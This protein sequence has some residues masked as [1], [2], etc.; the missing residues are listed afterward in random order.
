MKENILQLKE[1]QDID[2]KIGRLDKEIS[3][4]S[5]ALARRQAG[6]A[7][8]RSGIQDLEERITASGQRLREIEAELADE[9]ARLKDRQAKLMNVQTNRE[10]Q[11]LLKETEDIKRA[12][13][14]R[15]EE[16]VQLMEQVEA[17][18]ARITEESNVCETEEKLL[19]EEAERTERE[20]AQL[21]AEKV[22]IV[23][24]RESKAGSVPPQLLKKYTTIR[25]KRNGLA[26]VAVSNNVC[27]GCF[28]NIPSQLYN[29]L[30]REDKLLSCPTCHRIMFHQPE[31]GEE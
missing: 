18:K 5:A 25:E 31:A 14:Q 22:E 7:A 3:E 27:H 16:V 30:M 29:E 2:L 6:I 19:A 26:V 9:L 15:E 1:L 28:M 13:R 21:V 17:L 11:S 24:A 4:G 23:K 8:R 12:N 20:T 10:Y